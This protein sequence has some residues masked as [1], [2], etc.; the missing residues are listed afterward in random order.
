MAGVIATGAEI[1]HPKKA[2]GE[3]AIDI[4]REINNINRSIKVIEEKLNNV[5]R[6]V[7]INEENMLAATKKQFDEIKLINSEIIDMKHDIDEIKEK[8]KLI[9]KELKLTAKLEDVSVLQ[10]YLELWEP[11]NFVTRGEFERRL[12]EIRKS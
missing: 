2:E 8:I 7:Q 6:K 1:A 11:A 10:K 12:E 4:P 5:R 3:A 9:V